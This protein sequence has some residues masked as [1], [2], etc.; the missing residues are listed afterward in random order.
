MRHEGLLYK[1]KSYGISG[2]FFILIQYYQTRSGLSPP[3]L[4]SGA[5]RSNVV[6][7]F[8]TSSSVSELWAAIALSERKKSVL[9]IV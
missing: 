8:F 9:I 3:P 6:A 7:A 2:P 1:L 4:L 5:A